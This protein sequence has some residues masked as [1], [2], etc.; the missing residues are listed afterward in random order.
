MNLLKDIII[1]IIIN[2][3]N[4]F[5]FTLVKAKSIRI[6][7]SMQRID[8]VLHFWLGSVLT[9]KSKYLSLLD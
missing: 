4:F 5:M 3:I 6:D 1:I 9:I 7:L 8:Y 2:F